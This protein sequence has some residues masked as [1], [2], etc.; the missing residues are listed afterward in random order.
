MAKIKAGIVGCGAIG[1]E[2]ARYIDTQIPHMELVAICD[3]VPQKAKELAD[4][5]VRRPV[6]IDIAKVIENSELVIEAA[7]KDVAKEAVRLCCVKSKDV[8][9][10]STGGIIE[11]SGLLDLVRKKGIKLYFPS[12]AITGLDGLKGAKIGE[13]R[14]VT[15]TTKKPPQALAGAPFIIQNKINVENIKEETLLFEGSALEAV[16]GF[17]ANIN[18]AATL[19]LAGIG[20]KK[21]RVRIFAS[22]QLNINVHEIEV[23]GEFGKFVTRTENLPSP[24]NPRT[25]YLAVLSAMAVLKQIA[26]NVK[27]GT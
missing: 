26:D 7:S 20:P 25:S 3:A 1:G 21:T 18:V 2:L 9:V 5:L 10:M 17:P 6:I 16:S 12:G 8:L 14:S 27:V 24:K 11:D 19:S 22:P 15:L 23:T 13:I 4:N